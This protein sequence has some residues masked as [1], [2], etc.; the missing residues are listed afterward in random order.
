MLAEPGRHIDALVESHHDVSAAGIERGA[1]SHPQQSGGLAGGRALGYDV[2]FSR[3]AAEHARS[4]QKEV[5]ETMLTGVKGLLV[6]KI[7]DPKTLSEEI[8]QPYEFSRGEAGV[9]PAEFNGVG[10]GHRSSPVAFGG[11]ESGGIGLRV[12]AESVGLRAMG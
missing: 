11:M 3:Q 10:C 1:P 6:C 9:L 2:T 12:L 5:P 8:T 4:M 7:D